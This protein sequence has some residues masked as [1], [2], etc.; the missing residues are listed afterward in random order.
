MNDAPEPDGIPEPGIPLKKAH[1]RCPIVGLGASAGGLEAYQAFLTAM[2]TDAGLALVL[3]QHLDPNHKSM[4]AELL[5]R[6]TSMPV[7]QVSGDTP[8]EPNQVYLLPPN[9]NLVIV[10]GVLQL[11]DLAQPRGQRAPIDVFF[12]SLA[13]DQGENSAC[14]VLSGTGSDGTV[15]LRAIKECGGLTIAQAGE[16]AKYDGMPRSAAATG[17]VD[18]VLP[19]EEMPP[20]LIEY[21]RHLVHV[22]GRKNED[23]LLHE[24]GDYLTKI[25]AILRARTGHDFSHYKKNTLIRR[26]QRRMQVRQV[27]DVPAYIG[28]MRNTDDEA[29]QLFRDL[30]INVTQF[31]RDVE[32]FEALERDVI[33]K[34]V[35]G[36]GKDDQIRVWVPGCSTGEEAYSLAMLID[37][38]L[39]DVNPRPR[40]QIF[41]SD[42]D[43]EALEIARVGRYSEA[44]SKDISKDRLGRYFGP[45]DD[46]YRIIKDLRDMCIFSM[47][48]V[49]KDPPFSKLDLI[50]CRNLL[51]Y[52]GSELQAKLLP[53]FHYALKSE[54]YLFLGPSENITQ[55]GRLFSVVDSANRIF[56]RRDVPTASLEFPLSGPADF[57][58]EGARQSQRREPDGRK[59]EPSV[60][61]VAERLIL[62]FYGPPYAVVNEKGDI[63]HVSTRTGKYLE[64]PSGTPVVNVID[65]ARPGLRND[66]RIALRQ[67]VREHRRII[68]R[69]LEFGVNGGHQIIDL[70]VH[71]LG[72]TDHFAVIFQDVGSTRIDSGTEESRT[73]ESP[74]SEDTRVQDLETELQ[75]AKERL[76]TTIEELETSNEEL[77]SSNEEMMSMNEELQSANEELETSKEELQSINEELETVNSELRSKLDELAHANSDLQNLFDSTQIASIFLN[78]ELCIKNF[79]PATKQIFRLIDSDRGRPLSDLAARFPLERLDN[80]VAGVIR[81]REPVEREVSYGGEAGSHFLMRILPYRTVGNVI[82]GV[83]LTFVDVTRLKRAETQVARLNAILRDRIGDLEALLDVVPVGIAIADSPEIRELRLNR[84][85][86]QLMGIDTAAPTV[87]EAPQCQ[88]FHGSQELAPEELPL[89]RAA[90]SGSPV[91]DAELVLQR[92]DGT[93]LDIVAN[94]MPLFHAD[95]STRG[96]ILAFDDYSAIREAQRRSDRQARQQAEVARLGTLALAGMPSEELGTECVRTLCDV[97]GVDRCAVFRQDDDALV[98]ESGYGWP[99]SDIGHTSIDFSQRSPTSLTIASGQPVSYSDLRVDDRFVPAGLLASLGILSGASV[100]IAGADHSPYGALNAW[101]TLPRTFAPEEIDFVS[102]IANILATALRRQRDGRRLADSEARYR[103]VMKGIRD[104]A[105]VF[106][107][108]D[109]KILG[110]VQET[111]AAARTLL[112]YGDEEF[113]RLHMSDLLAPPWP[114]TDP[115]WLPKLLEHGSALAERTYRDHEG[116]PIAV[117]ESATL[118]SVNQQ[119]LVVILAR[120]IRERKENERQRDILMRELQHRVKNTLATVSAI[121]DLTGRHATDFER[122]K[123]QVNSRLRALAR[124]HAKLTSGH[125]G[126]VPFVELIEDVLSPYKDDAKRITLSGEAIS[127]A[128]KAALCLNLALHELATNAAK[129]GALSVASGRLSVVWRLAEGSEGSTFEIRWVESEGPPVSPPATRGFGRAVVEGGISHD[130]DGIVD[131]DFARE[132]LQCRI[133]IPLEQAVGTELPLEDGSL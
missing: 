120:D 119:C 8:V 112:G 95:G 4:L 58:V 59:G 99:D 118:I 90:A 111:N 93:R 102:S 36:R 9:K 123:E 131:L 54:G 55:Y 85:A 42:I 122:F 7:Q 19:V 89:Q 91:S 40:V 37:E 31:F 44:I 32:A 79:T 21:F 103:A 6:C 128:P 132:G 10:N 110:S 82:D 84:R 109:G 62:D 47:H 64:L 25:C 71:P 67:S 46:D 98:L 23:G 100:P 12:R 60:E 38:R 83:V 129:Y 18:Y 39:R 108:E 116:T 88:Y 97:L 107:L 27:S 117:E 70:V 16:S 26:I 61:R 57:Q 15:G 121:I 94:A 17:L 92:S 113:A 1:A 51:I 80:E 127:L 74:I 125:W 5:A 50:S 104:A 65:M 68:Q 114:A 81:T 3:I 63:A 72:Q 30:L 13:Q 22:G 28:V 130:L 101:S 115:D 53:I 66:V 76:R 73:S 33:P 133:A 96:A 77:K 29:N 41:A 69:S 105:L 48:S 124:A 87:G 52:L 34:I 49:I 75:L 20:T 11:H 86:R 126:R 14:I 35:D 45:C 106:A 2:P 78:N 56:V 43:E 24:A